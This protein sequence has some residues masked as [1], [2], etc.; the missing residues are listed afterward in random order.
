MRRR[1]SA[2]PN[3]HPAASATA[4]MHVEVRS[5]STDS[6]SCTTRT[7]ASRMKNRRTEITPSSRWRVSSTAIGAVKIS[8]MCSSPTR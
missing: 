3:A 7:R 5:I 6:E 2:E 4:P 1:W 8:A